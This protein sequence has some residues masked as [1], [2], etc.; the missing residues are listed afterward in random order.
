[1]VIGEEECI[2]ASQAAQRALEIHGL[3]IVKRSP[4]ASL[5]VPSPS[6]NIEIAKE[7]QQIQGLEQQH[8]KFLELAKINPEP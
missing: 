7:E 2:Q 5:W 4:S 1:M 3:T 8:H 6:S